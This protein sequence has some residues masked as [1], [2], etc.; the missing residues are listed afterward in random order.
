MICIGT[1]KIAT[2]KFKQSFK[3]MGLECYTGVIV[4]WDNC[5]KKIIINLFLP[6]A[7]PHVRKKIRA[8]ILGLEDGP[9]LILN[10][11]ILKPSSLI[12][13]FFGFKEKKV[14]FILQE[15]QKTKKPEKS[16]IV[17]G[18]FFIR[19]I[20]QPTIGGQHINRR[21]QKCHRSSIV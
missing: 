17:K 7:N 14:S 11:D 15:K 8:R 10:I 4:C 18:V 1:V 6:L 13:L 3:N 9:K 2:D 16:E 21:H 5:F 20:S 12:I 19:V